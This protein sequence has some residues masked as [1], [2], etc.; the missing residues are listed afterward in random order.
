MQVSRISRFGRRYQTPIGNCETRRSSPKKRVFKMHGL[1][2]QSTCP[3]ACSSQTKRIFH[4]SQHSGSRTNLD[5]FFLARISRSIGHGEN[6][7]FPLQSL[8]ECAWYFLTAHRKA[9]IS[10][11]RTKRLMRVRWRM[12]ITRER[13]AHKARTTWLAKELCSDRQ[14]LLPSPR[15]SQPVGV[16]KSRCSSSARLAEPAL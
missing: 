11:R 1:R 10:Q 7:W 2:S 5:Q 15:E 3:E 6:C 13:G 14:S 8:Y 9:D 4:T 12:Q 16:A